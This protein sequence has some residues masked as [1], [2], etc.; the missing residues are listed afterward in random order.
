[1]KRNRSIF[2]FVF[3]AFFYACTKMKTKKNASEFLNGTLQ[4]TNFLFITTDDHAY[5][6]ISAFDSKLIRFYYDIEAWELYDLEKDPQELNNLYGN[7]AY[8]E[9]QSKFHKKLEQLR[10]IYKDSDS[11][12]QEFIKSDL[13]RLEKLQI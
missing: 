7:S 13:I 3:I 9:V 12:N 8:K 2:L 11:L 4:K 5:Q 10:I 6:A 1:M